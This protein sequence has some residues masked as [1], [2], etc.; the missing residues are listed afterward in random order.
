[1]GTRKLAARA[2][3][4]NPHFAMKLVNRRFKPV[5][6]IIITAF[7]IKKPRLRRFAKIINTNSY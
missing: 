2:K 3:R 1:M 6:L 7:K 4:I 5:A